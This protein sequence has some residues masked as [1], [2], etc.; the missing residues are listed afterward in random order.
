MGAQARGNLKPRKTN[1]WAEAKGVTMTWTTERRKRQAELIT[2]WKPLE[3]S[4]GPRTPAGKETVA[5]NPWKGGH[6]QK[7][8]ELARLV[9]LELRQSRDL[10]A[11]LK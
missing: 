11:S 2:T 9:N 8:R 7:L 1:Y 5:Q 3:R 6:R 10:V 4:T